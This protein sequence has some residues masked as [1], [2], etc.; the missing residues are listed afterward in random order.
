MLIASW[1]FFFLISSDFTI[2]SVT[3]PVQWQGQAQYCD[4]EGLLHSQWRTCQQQVEGIKPAT[5]K[6]TASQNMVC[7]L[8]LLLKLFVLQIS[9]LYWK[10][11]CPL[12]L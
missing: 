2:L 9:K 7:L 8:Q 12:S 6:S 3:V 1:L 11:D 10:E 5:L 4:S